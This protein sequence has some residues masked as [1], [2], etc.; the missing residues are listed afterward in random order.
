MNETLALQPTLHS[1]P[2][3]EPAPGWDFLSL[4]RVVFYIII[5]LKL[6]ELSFLRR[7]KATLKERIHKKFL[8]THQEVMKNFT[9]EDKS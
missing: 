8:F 2:Q 7:K 3:Q 1:I 9:D 4:L 5:T 6:I